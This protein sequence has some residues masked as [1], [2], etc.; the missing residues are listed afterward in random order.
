MVQ[1]PGLLE[2]LDSIRDSPE[3]ENCSKAWKYLLDQCVRIEQALLAWKNTM[4]DDISDFEYSPY[5][6]PLLTP[7][8]DRDFAVLHLSYFYWSCSII[9]YTTIH[10]AATEASRW[11]IDLSCSPIPF[12]SHGY[13]KYEDERNPT[14]H[15]H[16]IVHA[17]PLSY[18]PNG[19][20]YAA[21]DTA[22]PLGLALR[23]LVVA[24]L[25][26][27]EGNSGNAQRVLL[28]ETLSK[29]F[30]GAYVAR[31]LENL[32]KVDAPVQGLKDIPGWHGVESRARRF[33]FGPLTG[34]KLR[35]AYANQEHV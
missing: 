16:R 12:S 6:K 33:W 14:L 11:T 13:P 23:Y 26:P 20:G 3:A 32:M 28:Q 22:F 9:L 2:R 34:K 18:T 30:M 5:G 17:L 10:I 1:I 15:A 27:H 19:G 25:F 8:I 4:R 31:F 7:Q 35:A 21:L 29:P 24:H